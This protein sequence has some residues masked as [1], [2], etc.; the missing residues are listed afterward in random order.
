[1]YMLHLSGWRGASLPSSPI[2]PKLQRLQLPVDGSVKVR[3]H[4]TCVADACFVC[5]C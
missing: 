5:G 4:Y 2:A 1:M 3:N